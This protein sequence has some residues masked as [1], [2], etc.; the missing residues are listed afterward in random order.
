MAPELVTAAATSVAVS[1]TT[2]VKTLVPADPILVLVTVTEAVV[3]PELRP[4]VQLKV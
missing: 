4:S 1:F 2:V 3:H